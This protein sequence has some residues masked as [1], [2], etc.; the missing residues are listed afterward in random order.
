MTELMVGTIIDEVNE[1]EHSI[2][3]IFAVENE[4]KEGVYKVIHACTEYVGS[5][6]SEIQLKSHTLLLSDYLI[7]TGRG[8]GRY[9]VTLMINRQFDSCMI[10]WFDGDIV[11]PESLSYR[12]H[13]MTT[14]KGTI[15]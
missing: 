4:E 10:G 13:G 14:P 2:T 1:D 8:V 6:V 15:G 9:K 3:V 7:E 11:R 5:D 12:A